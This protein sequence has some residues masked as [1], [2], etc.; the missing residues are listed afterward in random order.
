M[1][2]PTNLI[3]YGPPGTGKTFTTAY[4]A[5]LLCD[6]SAPSERTA[7]MERYNAL[8]EAGRIGFVTFHQSYDYESFVE[9]LR[10]QAIEGGTGFTLEPTPGI[11]REIAQLALEAGRP[12]VDEISDTGASRQG[13]VIGKRQVFKMSLGESGTEEHIYEDALDTESISLG[14]GGGIDWTPFD[15]YEAK[16]RRKLRTIPAQF[17]QRRKLRL[18]AGASVIDDHLLRHAAGDILAQILS[19]QGKRKIDPSTD[20]GRSPD[21]AIA[22]MDAVWL[23]D[24]L[25]KQPRQQ[26]R[27]PP[28]RG[29]PP[30]I[31]RAR[32][33][34]QKSAG[35]YAAQPPDIG[36]QIPQKGQNVGITHGIAT[37]I[38]AH[39]DQRVDHACLIRRVGC[40]LNS[41]GTAHRPTHGR[42]QNEAIGVAR[43]PPGDLET[44]DRPAGV[45]DLEIGI[46][47]KANAA[48]H[49]AK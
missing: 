14:W 36:G 44:G 22:D 5:V 19:D 3:L 45:E 17:R 25:G 18:A 42:E 9:G 33:R 6:G 29:G 49:G 39:H 31:E 26:R 11:F 48:G 23:N 35:T 47:D 7:L 37:A 15:S 27:P 20:P 16:Q 34:Q 1:P 21:T 28:M 32:A 10:P 8:R 46:K 30:P 2:N 41:S 12:A 40:H 13:L 24:D 38:A 43:H 4:E